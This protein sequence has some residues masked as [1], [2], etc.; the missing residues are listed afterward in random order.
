MSKSRLGNIAHKFQH[1]KG[2]WN[3]FILPIIKN[4]N[5]GFALTTSS[6]MYVAVWKNVLNWPIVPNTW[7]VKI[8]TN[9]SK[10]KVV[11]FE[12]VEFQLYQR[13]ALSPR[14]RFSTIASF[15][16]TRSHFYMPSNPDAHPTFRFGKTMCRNSQ[17]RL[18]ITKTNWRVPNSWK[19]TMWLGSLSFHIRALEW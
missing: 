13:E 17:H 3:N 12:D 6:V 2:S 1:T 16:I 7:P 10:E 15:S 18:R 14:R 5:F 11:A 9:L 19:V 8:N 4:I